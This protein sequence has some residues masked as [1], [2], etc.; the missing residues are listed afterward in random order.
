MRNACRADFILQ[1]D[2][3]SQNLR[4]SAGGRA[5]NR[6][7]LQGLQIVHAI[8][9]RLHR[10]AVADTVF[11]IEPETRRSLEAGA[12]RDENVLRDVARLQADVLGASAVDVEVERWCIESLL[13]VNINCAGNVTHFAR[14]FFSEFVIDRLIGDRPQDGNVDGGR[15]AEIQDLRDDVRWLE[16]KL[17]SGESFREF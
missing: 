12:E 10:D 7:V 8:L 9:W 3:V 15:R 6:S 1:R 16:I 13:D 11:R 4:A 2:E 5:V 14:K 17:N